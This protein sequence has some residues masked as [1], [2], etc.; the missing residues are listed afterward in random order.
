[1]KDLLLTATAVGNPNNR[2]ETR[3]AVGDPIIP[4]G[5]IADKIATFSWS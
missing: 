4:A 2:Y 5:L 3:A 1:M